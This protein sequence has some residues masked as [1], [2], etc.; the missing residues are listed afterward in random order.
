M[1]LKKSLLNSTTKVEITKRREEKREMDMLKLN[2][3]YFEGTG[4]FN[5]IHGESSCI[6]GYITK[7]K[8]W[9]Y[10]RRTPVSDLNEIQESQTMFHQQNIYYR[11]SDYSS[12]SL[13]LVSALYLLTSCLKDF[14][15][16]FHP[17]YGLYQRTSL[18]PMFHYYP[19]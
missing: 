1:T 7:R 6:M 18:S 17:F 11:P 14:K 4:E 16:L 12:F 9:H 8:R 15:L 13:Y 10:I 19:S 5:P 3:K 2:K